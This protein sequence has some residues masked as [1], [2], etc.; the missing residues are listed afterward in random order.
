MGL[1][2][3]VVKQ[4]ELLTR[5]VGVVRDF[6]F[7]LA[8]NDANMIGEG[9]AELWLNKDELTE[10]A[11]EFASDWARSEGEKA[12]PGVAVSAIEENA[13]KELIDWIGS[14]PWDDDEITLHL[15]W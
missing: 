4:E 13:V 1:D 7:D 14:L 2:V 10:K 9:N 15:N 8:A 12:G 11:K 5:P 3:W 6:C